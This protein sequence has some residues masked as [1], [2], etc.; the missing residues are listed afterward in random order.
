MF[1]NENVHAAK[2]KALR[3]TVFFC[4]VLLLIYIALHAIYNVS[5]GISGFMYLSV[6]I[7]SAVL[8]AVIIIKGE[9]SFAKNEDEK[10]K[11]YAKSFFVL[12]HFFFFVYAVSLPYYYVN[13]SNANWLPLNYIILFMEAPVWLCLITFAKKAETQ[14]EEKREYYKRV[15]K[16][17]LHFLFMCIGYAMAAFVSYVLRMI[18]IS[19]KAFDISALLVILVFA[20]SIFLS[21]SVEYL[22]YSL[23]ERAS[24]VAREK[25][26]I[27]VTTLV[28]AA[29]YIFTVILNSVMHIVYLHNTKSGIISGD[30]VQ[31]MTTA[32]RY[33]EILMGFLGG[34]FLVYIASEMSERVDYRLFKIAQRSIFVIILSH[35]YSCVSPIITNIF[36]RKYIMFSSIDFMNDIYPKIAAVD[37]ILSI[38][39]SALL[40]IYSIKTIRLLSENGV[41]GSV[42]YVYPV[43]MFVLE[44][45]TLF[46][47]I[48]LQMQYFVVIDALY[49]ALAALFALSCFKI[50]KK[51]NSETAEK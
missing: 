25:G 16:N 23:A 31:S 40:V 29:A 50:K 38:V 39:I 28:I 10:N 14:K 33:I 36:H 41:I 26:K 34:A 35:A 2:G 17:I 13:N 27:S 6:E 44:V 30:Y 12:F 47:T 3:K 5:F 49:I 24:T 37:S 45:A 32:F 43:G 15:F 11:W 9:V 19:S 4:E 51:I 1:Y 7:L 42:A 20:A 21:I 48:V 18:F 46:M 8:G 22:L